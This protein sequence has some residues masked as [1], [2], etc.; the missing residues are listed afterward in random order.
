M[1]PLQAVQNAHFVKT[2]SKAVF[3][4]PPPQ[5]VSSALMVIIW[6]PSPEARLK[7]NVYFVVPHSKDVHTA[8]IHR[9]V[10]TVRMVI[11]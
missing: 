9:F 4:A 11:I 8:M 6:I 1:I 7:M 2:Y 3:Y 5:F 10:Y